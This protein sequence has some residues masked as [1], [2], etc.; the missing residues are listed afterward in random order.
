MS[1]DNISR[2]RLEPCKDSVGGIAKV[3][4]VNKGDIEGVTY[5]VTDSDAID[6]V[7][8]TPSAY[9]FEVEVH[10]LIQRQLLQVERMV[11]LTLNKYWSY[12]YLN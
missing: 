1:C 3:Y 12:N 6:T 2:G 11:L 5:D 9:E 4:F 8:G 10:L 7:T